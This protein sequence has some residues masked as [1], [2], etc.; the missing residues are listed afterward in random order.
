MPNCFNFR[1]FTTLCP[2]DHDTIIARLAAKHFSTSNERRRV[3]AEQNLNV[4][5]TATFELAAT[6]GFARMSM[7]DL[8]KASGLSLGGLYNYFDSKES[9]AL[10]IADALHLVAFEWLPTLTDETMTHEQQL[11]HL[12]RG[13]I[14]LS[15][16]LRPW[17]YFVFMESKNLPEPN[18][19]SARS[20]ELRFQSL[21]ATLLGEDNLHASHIMALMQDWHVKHWKYRSVN[22][23]DFADSVVALSRHCLPG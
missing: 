20:V 23:D 17:F 6:I 16:T 19:A 10:M 21:I 7:R 12:I 15:E 1:E 2:L 9:L 22:I 3:K 8:H 5:I 4:I 13:H 11:E 18:K 14:Y